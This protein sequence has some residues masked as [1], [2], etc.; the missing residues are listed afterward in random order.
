MARL[1][2][3]LAWVSEW[4][5]RAALSSLEAAEG[6]L[7]QLGVLAAG[8]FTLGGRGRAAGLLLADTALLLL[9]CGPPPFAPLPP[10][11][12]SSSPC[13]QHCV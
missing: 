3:H 1:P 13:N 8:C 10:P 2:P 9:R 4:R 7:L 5:L 12:G 6:L 11:L